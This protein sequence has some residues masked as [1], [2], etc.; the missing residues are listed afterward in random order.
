MLEH[1]MENDVE[2]GIV[3]GFIGSGFSGRLYGFAV[4]GVIERLY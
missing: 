4:K 3:R 1:Q 2:A